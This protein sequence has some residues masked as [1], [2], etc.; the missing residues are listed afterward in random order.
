MF[1]SP[2]TAKCVYDDG[3]VAFSSDGSTGPA[4]FSTS[5]GAKTVQAIDQT[6]SASATITLRPK[7]SGGDDNGALPDTGG[8]NLSLFLIA[9]GLVLVGG[10]VTYMARRR[11]SS[12]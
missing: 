2:I 10:G 1:R 7:G 3:Q 8:S 4:F 6:A 12:H 5:N 11:Q 9:G